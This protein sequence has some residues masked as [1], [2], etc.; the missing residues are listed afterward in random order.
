MANNDSKNASK[1]T[2]TSASTGPA[3]AELFAEADA[4]KILG[5]LR[6]ELNGLL[7]K[8]SRRL[9]RYIVVFYYQPET[10]TDDDTDDIYRALKRS[11]AGEKDVLM[12]LVANGGQVQPAYQISKLC[13][14]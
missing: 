6:S 12:L 2:A 14:D 11:P 4:D 8:W 13:R 7:K 5:R 10:M 3:W 1:T 9:Q